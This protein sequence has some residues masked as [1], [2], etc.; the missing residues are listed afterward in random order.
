MGGKID[1]GTPTTP[2][3]NPQARKTAPLEQ[4]PQQQAKEQPRPRQDGLAISQD[5]KKKLEQQQG[6]AKRIWDDYVNNPIQDARKFW[7]DRSKEGGLTGFA[8]KAFGAVL[9]FSGVTSIAK[10][11]STALDGTKDTKTRAKAAAWAL[12]EVAINFIPVGKIGGVGAKVFKVTGGTKLLK[13]VRNATKLGAEVKAGEKILH[14]TTAANAAK[15]AESGMLKGSQRGFLSMGGKGGHWALT[16]EGLERRFLN[17]GQ[18]YALA[19]DG[20]TTKVAGVVDAIVGV[21]PESKLGKLFGKVS[22]AKTQYDAVVEHVLTAEEAARSVR[23]GKTI[24]TNVPPGWKGIPLATSEVS[25][26]GKFGAADLAKSIPNQS[27]SLG[28]VDALVGGLVNNKDMV[29]FAYL[30][31]L[32]ESHKPQN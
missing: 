3:A 31:M 10:N 19:A 32:A 4:P 2:L 17:N 21:A 1:R 25:K 11:T 8:G 16:K 14:Y 29:A 18:V 22:P 13:A 7:E 28:P 12:G 15:I 26:I 27:V 20:K 5:A 9:D 23:W 24:V 30:K 6:D